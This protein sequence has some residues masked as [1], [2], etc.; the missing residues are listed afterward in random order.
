M[1]LLSH[2]ERTLGIYLIIFI[3][4]VA[5]SRLSPFHSEK[6]MSFAC[7]PGSPVL[8]LGGN[9]VGFSEKRQVT[10]VTPRWWG[11]VRTGRGRVRTLF[12]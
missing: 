11:R 12:N 9:T 10:P 7:G 2:G 6:P 1:L 4:E 8:Q 5:L 3:Q